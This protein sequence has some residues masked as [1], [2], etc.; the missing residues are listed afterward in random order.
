MKPD[1]KKAGKKGNSA[2]A[3]KNQL[4]QK[5]ANKLDIK[6]MI[7]GKFGKIMT[8]NEKKYLSDTSGSTLA[9]L[10]KFNASLANSFYKVDDQD[11]LEVA[12]LAFQSPD[13]I[14]K[15]ELSPK[16]S[17]A[18]KEVAIFRDL[19]LLGDLPTITQE[20]RP[21][22][23]IYTA[24][25]MS[26]TGQTAL[27]ISLLCMAIKLTGKRPGKLNMKVPGGK[28]TGRGRDEVVSYLAIMQTVAESMADT[29]NYQK[30]AKF[31]KLNKMKND[32]VKIIENF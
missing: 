24:P 31:S 30:S 15:V 5:T 3:S 2:N 22:E 26:E 28:L 27:M 1:V 8:R 19:L 20:L 14:G 9:D 13:E 12:L 10:A 21:Y 32:L 25:S 17:E 4:A 6:Q 7:D 18:F 11:A 23:W 16:V 29:N